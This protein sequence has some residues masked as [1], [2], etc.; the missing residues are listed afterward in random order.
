MYTGSRPIIEFINQWRE[1]NT[2]WNDGNC[3]S[4]PVKAPKIFFFFGLLKLLLQLR[5]QHLHF[6]FLLSVTSWTK[7]RR[8]LIVWNVPN[9]VLFAAETNV[10]FFSSYDWLIWSIHV[11]KET[12][13]YRIS[14][15]IFHGPYYLQ[16]AWHIDLASI[17]KAFPRNLGS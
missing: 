6:P 12:F 9:R 1:W 4:N 13:F 11:Y 15:Y 7:L 3:G 17:G 5:W 2:E 10:F 16:L 14:E 8:L